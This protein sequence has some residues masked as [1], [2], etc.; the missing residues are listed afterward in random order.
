[1]ANVTAKT[2]HDVFFKARCTVSTHNEES[3]CRRIWYEAVITKMQ[4]YTF[5]Q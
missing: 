3:R 1:M 2:S 5:L 4:R